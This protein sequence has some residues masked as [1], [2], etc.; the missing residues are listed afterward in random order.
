[1]GKTTDRDVEDLLRGAAFSNLEHKRAVHDKLFSDHLELSP[2]D[3]ADV[4]GGLS[5]DRPFTQDWPDQ[6]RGKY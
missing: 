3:L 1:M 6:D 2:D 5:Y 4:T